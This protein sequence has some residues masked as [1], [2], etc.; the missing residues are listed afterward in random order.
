MCVYVY[1]YLYIYIYVNNDPAFDCGLHRKVQKEN[2]T[3]RIFIVVIVTFRISAHN[4][5]IHLSRR[6][7]AKQQ[8]QQN[9]FE[10]NDI[11]ANEIPLVY[12]S[13]LHCLDYGSS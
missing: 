1:T 11:A 5:C 10:Y 6:G 13:I 12:D 4:P 2:G 3:G 7:Y 9:D 8:Q